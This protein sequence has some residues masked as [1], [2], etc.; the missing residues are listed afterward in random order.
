[1]DDFASE[2]GLAA[3]LFV[4]SVEDRAGV[5]PDGDAVHILGGEFHVVVSLCQHRIEFRGTG[6]EL[7]GNG[8]KAVAVFPEAVLRRQAEVGG[9]PFLP[10]F[11]DQ[12]AVQSGGLVGVL[13]MTL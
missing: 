9:V 2:L 13:L 3:F 11:D 1:M 7:A 6:A 5:K 4:D 8:D 10:A 12:S